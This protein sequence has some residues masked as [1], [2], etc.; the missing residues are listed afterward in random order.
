M[1][2]K[3]IAALTIIAALGMG[4]Y[5]ASTDLEPTKKTGVVE[6]TQLDWQVADEEIDCEYAVTPHSVTLVKGGESC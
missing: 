1:M 2:T 5:A 4:A 6:V 3:T